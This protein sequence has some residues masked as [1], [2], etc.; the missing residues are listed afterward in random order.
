MLSEFDLSKP[1]PDFTPLDTSISILLNT[2]DD[3][4]Q[5]V[6]HVNNNNHAGL[7]K[8][9]TE[10]EEQSS[11]KGGQG[12]SADVLKKKEQI[13]KDVNRTVEILNQKKDR[14]E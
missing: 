7:G 13:I 9:P 12:L 2:L 6:L 5:M 3:I 1:L 10:K 14:I 8:P 11:L 4:D